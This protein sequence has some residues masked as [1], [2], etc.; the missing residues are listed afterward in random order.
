MFRFDFR[1][2]LVAFAL[3]S[4]NA[5][6]GDVIQIPDTVYLRALDNALVISA[7]FSKPKAGCSYVPAPDL[8]ISEKY[9]EDQ[10][11]LNI[12][13]VRIS[14]KSK[15]YC[16]D[17]PLYPVRDVVSKG[18]KMGEK[19]LTRPGPKTI[20]LNLGG[21][22]NIFELQVKK[23]VIYVTS[24]SSQNVKFHFPPPPGPMSHQ[25]SDQWQFEYEP[26]GFNDI[27]SDKPDNCFENGWCRFDRLGSKPALDNFL[28]LD[29]WVGLGFANNKFAVW[30]GRTWTLIPKEKT[31]EECRRLRN[32]IGSSGHLKVR[33]KYG[34]IECISGE[35]ATFDGELEVRLKN[36]RCDP[37]QILRTVDSK[38]YWVLCERRLFH[39]F[40]ENPYQNWSLIQIA[41]PVFWP[42]G[43]VKNKSDYVENFSGDS[44]QM[45]FVTVKNPVFRLDEPKANSFRVYKVENG[46]VS[47]EPRLS[48]Q[49]AAPLLSYRKRN[50]IV[51]C[52]EKGKL[53]YF[54]DGELKTSTPPKEFVCEVMFFDGDLAY[55]AGIRRY[56][57]GSSPVLFKWKNGEWTE[58]NLGEGMARAIAMQKTDSAIF[59]L[60]DHALYR[61]PRESQVTTYRAP[62]KCHAVGINDGKNRNADLLQ[63]LGAD[64]PTD[65]MPDYRQ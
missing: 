11:N 42:E 14:K 41:G 39:A 1:F 22:A 34:N 28:I 56:P 51:L 54:V 31:E 20:K 21:I 30:Y 65:S 7:N 33:M 27:Y 2:V 36:L 53:I 23:R 58:V 17:F 64:R 3:G 32:Q 44:E 8:L 18:I 63:I 13:G 45:W 61:G 29:D 19:W 16:D 38:D 9:S 60:T 12:Q 15:V 50:D 40:R 37:G 43:P 10:L 59:L 57:M 5:H 62:L 26:P 25:S 49:G 48:S 47:E 6:A 52:D 35:R 4:V 55:I 46:L 24:V